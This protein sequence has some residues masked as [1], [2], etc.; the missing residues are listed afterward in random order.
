MPEK[1]DFYSNLNLENN[2]DADYIHGKRVCNV[3]EIKNLGG[4]HGLYLNSDTLLLADVFE[5][6]WKISLE[7][8]QLDPARFLSA[9]ELVW[10]TAFKKTKVELEVL[11]DINIL[12]MV[13]KGTKGEIC[14]PINRYNTQMQYSA[15]KHWSSG[16][17]EEVPFQFSQDV[18]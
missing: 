4:Y 18:P 6:F 1:D 11:A 9:P 14:H 13:E 10:Q 12:L 8:Y 2:T 17:P 16:R 3:F 5:N 7:I 15:S